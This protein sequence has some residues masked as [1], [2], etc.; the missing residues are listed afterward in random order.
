MIVGI[1]FAANAL[2]NFLVGLLVAKFLGPTEYGRFA[3]AF[4]ASVMINSAGFDW[5]RLSAIR[6]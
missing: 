4:A 6:F 3:I 1:A 5:I 2:A